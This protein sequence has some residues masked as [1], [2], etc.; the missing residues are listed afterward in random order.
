MVSSD[1]PQTI[2]KLLLVDDNDA[3]RRSFSIMLRARG[4]SV[5]TYRSGV[6]VLC[7]RVLPDVD[8]LLI[9]YKM[10]GIDGLELLGRLRCKGLLVP[11]LMITGYISSTLEVRARAVGF[12]DIIEKPPPV[13][14]LVER[15]QRL[16]E[17]PA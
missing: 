5:E 15:I 8:C 9:D 6:E 2:G 16:F 12:A 10:P 7:N 14:L 3:V 11:A 4:Y 1:W 13:D 17:P